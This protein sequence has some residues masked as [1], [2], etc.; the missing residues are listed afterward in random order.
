MI[1]E[2]PDFKL[3]KRFYFQKALQAEIKVKTFD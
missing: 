3:Q 1:S 2:N